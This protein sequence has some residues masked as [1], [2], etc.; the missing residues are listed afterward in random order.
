V[1]CSF[2]GYEFNKA[3]GRTSCRGCP[4]AGTC[5]KVSCPN[6]GYDTPLEPRLFKA[7]KARRGKG[8]GTRRK[9]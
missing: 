2:C 1:K 7:L 8:N 3:E 4:M 5:R 9:R 6:C